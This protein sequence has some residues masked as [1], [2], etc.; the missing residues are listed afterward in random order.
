MLKLDPEHKLCEN[1]ISENV[2]SVGTKEKGNRHI[3]T[4]VDLFFFFLIL[5]YPLTTFYKPNH[6]TL[7]CFFH[8]SDTSESITENSHCK[9]G[10][11][12]INFCLKDPRQ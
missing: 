9:V 1:E 2:E 11:E 5:K 3:K 10:R 8:G 7:C 4:A 12:M 6:K